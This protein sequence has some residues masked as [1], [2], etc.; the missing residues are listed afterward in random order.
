MRLVKAAVITAIVLAIIPT[1]V[2]SVNKI[3]GGYTKRVEYEII[4][5]ED[6]VNE[7]V[8]ELHDLAKLDD[9]NNVTNWL[10]VEKDGEIINVRSFYFNPSTNRY[11]I[12]YLDDTSSTEYIDLTIDGPSGGMGNYTKIVLYDEI[13][14]EPS[15]SSTE[16]IILISLIPLIL[17]SGLLVYQY[18]ELG[19]KIRKE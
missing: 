2:L 6:N 11:I 14:V 12:V 7:T 13:F 17:V 1:I 10:Y 15:V 5:T 18:K 4:I 19:L 16:L 8:Y 9:A 3:T